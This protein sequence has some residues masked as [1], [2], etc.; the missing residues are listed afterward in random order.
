[1][2]ALGTIVGAIASR[3]IQHPMDVMH[4]WSFTVVLLIETVRIGG[5]IWWLVSFSGGLD[6]CYM[7]T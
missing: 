3:F 5:F 7:G 6:I 2:S 4:V 1:M